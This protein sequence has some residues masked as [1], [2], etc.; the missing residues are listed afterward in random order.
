MAK[1]KK[2][3]GGSLFI[4]IAMV[5]VVIFVFIATRDARA[6][7]NSG[8]TSDAGDFAGGVDQ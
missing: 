3:A 6:Q 7:L 5:V 4:I 8:G 1:G 2:D